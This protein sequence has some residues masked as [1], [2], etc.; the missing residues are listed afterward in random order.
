MSLLAVDPGPIESGVVE[1]DTTSSRVLIHGVL[2]NETILEMLGMERGRFGA[3]IDHVAIEMIASY[4]MSVGKTVFETCIWIGRFIQQWGGAYTLIPRHDIKMHI[5]HTKNS[6]NANIREALID[7]WG[8]VDV[9]IGG[10]KLPGGKKAGRTP[11]GPLHGIASH[12]WSALAVAVT[13]QDLHAKKA[14]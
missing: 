12:E 4:G 14:A 7:R 1:Y 8:G 10:K 13:W 5:C 9:A 6:S 2:E 3:A 11:E